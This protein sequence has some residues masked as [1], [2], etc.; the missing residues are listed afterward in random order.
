MRGI[1][2]PLL[3]VLRS[4]IHIYRLFNIQL[5]GY[6]ACKELLAVHF[7]ERGQGKRIER[8]G[9]SGEC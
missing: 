1:I 8:T 9:V 5:I 4:L 2:S 7:A 3:V 6:R